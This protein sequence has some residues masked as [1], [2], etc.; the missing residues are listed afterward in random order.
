MEPS[1]SYLLAGFLKILLDK[2]EELIGFTKCKRTHTE[3][4]AYIYI[5]T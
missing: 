3:T 1:Y 2:S 4:R 5:H